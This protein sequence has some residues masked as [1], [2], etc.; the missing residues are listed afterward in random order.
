M[1][2]I[3]AY[4]LDPANCACPQLRLLQPA[5]Y[6]AE[7]VKV[8]WAALSE[9]DNYAVDETPMS[10]CDL[11]VIQR[12][13]PMRETW[14]LIEK[15]LA[16]P[17]PVLYEFDDDFLHLPP[18]HPMAASVKE[19][20][21]PWIER[22]L[23]SADR[24]SVTTRRLA[25]SHAAFNPRI[26]VL[27]NGLDP[28][29]WRLETPLRRRGG[30]GAVTIAMTGTPTHS[31]DLALVR[32]VVTELAARY[33]DGVRFL[34]YGSLPGWAEAL[35]SRS[36]LDFETDYVSFARRM[37]RLEVD[38]ALIPLADVGF[39]Q[40]KSDI[41]FLEYGACGIPGVF[42]D[43]EP[44]RATVRHGENGLLARTPEDWLEAAH[45]LVRNPKLRLAMGLRAREDTCGRSLRGPCGRRFAELWRSMVDES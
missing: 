41:K 33:R 29:L 1:L 6:A 37:Q 7:T 43:M 28:A 15:A 11:I 36:S 14:P 26:H 17:V 9:G 31:D 16:S 39:N 34:F 35:P 22:L 5:R 21:A 30:K 8:K 10:A 19:R 27:E 18:S 13:F 12:C 24:I 45:T 23:R 2:E 42:A 25:E 44:Y 40:A 20:C 4:S 38:F 32:P 3:A